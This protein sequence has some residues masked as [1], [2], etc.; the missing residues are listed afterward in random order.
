MI[1]NF[2]EISG[3]MDSRAWHTVH[4]NASDSVL[5]AVNDVQE[6]IEDRVTFQVRNQI[7]LEI[8]MWLQREGRIQKI[9]S[10]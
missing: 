7:W 9:R 2:S 8:G 1:T 3:Q 5:N 10:S 6:R 4:A